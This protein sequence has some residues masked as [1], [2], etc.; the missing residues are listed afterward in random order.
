MFKKLFLNLRYPLTTYKPIKK[1]TPEN[2]IEIPTAWKGL[3]LVIEDILDRF[4][5]GRDNC[6]EFGVEFGYSAVVFSNYFKKVKGI[7]IF[8]GDDH[9]THKGDHYDKTKK[10]LEQFENIDLYKSDYK[11][12]IKK[13][14]EHYDFAHVD[15]VHNYKETY[16]C[17]LWA[18]QHSKCCVFHDTESFPAVKKAVF[19]IAKHTGKKVYNYPHHHGLGIIV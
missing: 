3:E 10:S 16:E 4:D 18:V 19:D 5:I 8:I 1:S 17:G 13:D 11:D 6:I 7:D 9:T 15:I 2:I 12:W 14:K